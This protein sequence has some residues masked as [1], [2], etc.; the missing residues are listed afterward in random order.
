MSVVDWGIV[1][2]VGLFVLEIAVFFL[3]KW[4]RVTC[5]WLIGKKDLKPDIDPKNL[6]RFMAHG[7][8]KELGWAR[9]PNTFHSEIGANG[10]TTRYTIGADGARNS[11]GYDSLPVKALVYGDS[12]AFARQVNDKEAWP[13]LLAQKLG[14]RV[15]NF[16][17]G[18][19][20]IDQAQ[21]LLERHANT[22]WAP[23]V[24]MA[25]VPETISRILCVWKHFSEYGNI[26]AFKPRYTLVDKKLY[27]RKNP[28]RSYEGFFQ[29]EHLLPELME[30]D[31]FYSR[32]FSRDMLNFPYLFSL[33]KT[34]RRNVPLIWAALRDRFGKDG[35]LAFGEIMRRNT[36]IAADLY[37]TPQAI[38]L[39][40]AICLRFRDV[41]Y[42]RGAEPIL[43]FIPQLT[44]LHT[45]RTDGSYYQPL[46]ERLSDTVKVIDFTPVLMNDK[47][48]QQLYISDVYG[49]HLTPYGNQLIAEQ[50]A[51]QFQS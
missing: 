15:A 1:G 7:W 20:G 24:I 37:Q 21:M 5:P 2:L 43:V 38:D 29:I 22:I 35:N 26:F 40:E 18:N 50:L 42:E 11:P 33:M 49:G 36:A 44:D 13:H 4:L 25:V 23:V 45:V 39:L 51:R 28:M 10:V 12:Y 34:A 32:K 41:V 17:V 14:G 19:Y 6:D 3:V 31:W 30:H 9:K 27:T 47:S 8:D 46:L 16:G 48:G